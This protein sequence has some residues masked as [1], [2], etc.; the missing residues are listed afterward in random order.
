MGADDRQ[1]HFAEVRGEAQVTYTGAVSGR[2][3]ITA[4]SLN[5]R[6]RKR[7]EHLRRQISSISRSSQ[8]SVSSPRRIPPTGT[9]STCSPTSNQGHQ[10]PAVA[11]RD[12]RHAR[13]R[14]GPGIGTDHCRPR[15]AGCGRKPAGQGGRD[16][17]PLG[18]ARS[19]TI[20][21]QAIGDE[22]AFDVPPSAHSPL[23]GSAAA[24]RVSVGC[25]SGGQ[26]ALQTLRAGHGGPATK[27]TPPRNA[28]PRRGA[29]A[30]GRRPNPDIARQPAHG[31]TCG[32][33]IWNSGA[34]KT[35]R[36]KMGGKKVVRT[37]MVHSTFS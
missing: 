18:R 9:P 4:A 28:M 34:E 19:R 22:N 24:D 3:A 6:N 12:R 10:P 35:I 17:A 13:R 5:T 29:R 27:G 14:C 21:G 31:L 30:L 25:V 20:R 32:R 36:R 11:S 2:L 26:P 37:S 7:D 8:R 33:I 1:G 15:A 16:N 23:A